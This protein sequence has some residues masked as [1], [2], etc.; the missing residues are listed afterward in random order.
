MITYYDAMDGDLKFAHCIDSDCGQFTIKALDGAGSDD[1]GKY[2][3]M[4]VG[5]DGLPLIS[6]YD[7]TNG[8]LKMLHCGSPHCVAYQQAR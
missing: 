3:S 2:A 7:T 8:A 4:T 6:Y 1:V 5:V